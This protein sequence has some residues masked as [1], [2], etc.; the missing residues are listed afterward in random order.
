[1]SLASATP[2]PGKEVVRAE[3]VAILAPPGMLERY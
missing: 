1:M 2:A 3:D